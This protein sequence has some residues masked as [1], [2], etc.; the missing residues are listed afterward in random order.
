MYLLFSSIQVI[1]LSA[2][3]GAPSLSAHAPISSFPQR[4]D[5]TYSRHRSQSARQ[6]ETRS[7]FEADFNGESE[8]TGLSSSADL[9]LGLPLPSLNYQVG[10][11]K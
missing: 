3:R 11:L 6:I 4:T 1:P 8:G 2:R 7:L 5:L 10:R 9:D